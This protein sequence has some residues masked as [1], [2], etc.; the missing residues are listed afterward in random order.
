MD[1][2]RIKR[3]ID[4]YFN[5]SASAMGISSGYYA[6]IN[7]AERSPSGV[8]SEPVIHFIHKITKHR[9]I[10]KALLNLDKNQYRQLTAIYVDDY[11]SKYPLVIK[12][13]FKEKTGLLLCLTYDLPKMLTLCT[14]YR[15]KTMSDTER[16]SFNTIISSVDMQYDALHNIISKYLK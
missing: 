2:H 4:W 13:I 16:L 3:Q 12:N 1:I 10:H 15:Q 6:M 5:T 14:K 8:N 7:G 11:Q 9:K